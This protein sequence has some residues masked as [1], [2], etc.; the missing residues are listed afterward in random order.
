[1]VAI[2]L[3]LKQTA[4]IVLPLQSASTLACADQSQARSMLLEIPAQPSLAEQF[5]ARPIKVK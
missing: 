4:L 5:C 1:M 3:G 2:Y